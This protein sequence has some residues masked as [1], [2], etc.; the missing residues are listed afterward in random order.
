MGVRL[1]H[2]AD[3]QL[4]K[5]FNNF[6]PDAGARLRQARIEAVRRIAAIATERQVDAVLVA[7][8][9][10]DQQIA[11]IEVITGC[12]GAMGDF[13]GDWVLLPGN[14]DAAEEASVWERV[15]LRLPEGRQIH[16]AT[17]ANPV[18]LA[19]GRLA[20]L[21]APLLRRHESSDL[22]ACWD[23][24][25]TPPGAYRVG[26]AH[27]SVQGILPEAAEKHNPIA[28]DRAG[29]AQLDYLALGDW[30]GTLEAGDRA[31][32][33]G[34]P[35]PD[36]FKENDSGNVLLIE[37]DRPGAAPRVE[38]IP[39]GQYRWLAWERRITSG[40]DIEQLNR[41]LEAQRPTQLRVVR[42]RLDGT[43]ALPD[44]QIL[45]ERLDWWR[46]QFAVLRVE[47][48]RIQVSVGDTNFTVLQPPG[49][50]AK[51]VADLQSRAEA[52]EAGAAEA[53]QILYQLCVEAGAGA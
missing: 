16:L 49:Y 2:T 38:P 53:L 18:V 22:T 27:G 48:E 40:G 21:P 4:G 19:D 50:V 23:N 26:L 37:I 7:G 42:L 35:E 3:W 8:D 10:F 5:A 30:H 43:L 52:G 6:G 15:R 45:R 20:V 41:E 44:A 28:A 25:P 47:D 39:T 51:A 33:S 9:V 36:G 13:P 34:T 29:A 46:G 14:H 11:S 1:L 12:L 31:W 24:S 17:D 32:Y